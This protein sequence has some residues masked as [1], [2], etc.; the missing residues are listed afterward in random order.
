[1]IEAL[2]T[3]KARLLMKL[4]RTRD[5][6]DALELRREIERVDAALVAARAVQRHLDA[7]R[8]VRPPPAD[9][10]RAIA[11]LKRRLPADFKGLLARVR[12]LAS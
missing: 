6:N 7:A 11:A 9:L 12:E 1:M 3:L 10:V 4:S 8:E 5:V 2:K